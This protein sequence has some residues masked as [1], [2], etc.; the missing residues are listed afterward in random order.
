MNKNKIFRL[1]THY[2][3][4][5][6]VFIVLSVL[7]YPRAIK[8]MGNIS[9]DI[10]K[11]LPDDHPT[12]TLGQEMKQKFKKKGGGDLVVIIDSPNPENNKKLMLDLVQKFQSE[13]FIE[14][15][16]YTKEGFDFFSNHKLLYI[17]KDDLQE[18]K[19]RISRKIQREK[20]KGLCWARSPEI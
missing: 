15:V 6:A 2:W 1:L 9:T 8:L 7:S 14:N 3:F 13:P 19:D 10:S 18:I 12:V 4:L 17:D 5:S 20:L 16:L 11:L